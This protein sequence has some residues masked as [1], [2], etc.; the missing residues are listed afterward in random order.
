MV[1]SGTMI[2]FQ[3]SAAALNNLNGH[4]NLKEKSFLRGSINKRIV[5]NQDVN[6]IQFVFPCTE[7]LS[8]L[9]K[10]YLLIKESLDGLKMLTPTGLYLKM[11]MKSIDT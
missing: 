11:A 1:A 3:S 10:T 5:R 8:R 4:V 6:H 2:G 7:Y 9:T